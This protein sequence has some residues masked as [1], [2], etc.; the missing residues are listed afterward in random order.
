MS[1]LSNLKNKILDSKDRIVSAVELVP[2]EVA[3]MRFDICKSCPHLSE[4]TSQ[5]KK[6]GCFMQ[7]KTKLKT[8][9]CPI[10]KW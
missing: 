5:C 8:A 2:S 1:F 10:N 6:C 7:A 3:D 4:I 9:S